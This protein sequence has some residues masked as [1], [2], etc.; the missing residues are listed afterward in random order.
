MIP[1]KIKNNSMKR[2]KIAFKGLTVPEKIEKA[3]SI[4]DKMNGNASFTTPDP[5]LAEVTKAINDLEA[6][7]NKAA[8]GGKTN[9]AIM[10]Q[11]DKDLLVLITSL[12]GYVQSVSR[13]DEL[14]I[15]SSG[16]E[17]AGRGSINNAPLPAPLGLHVVNGVLE[18]QLVL[19]WKKVKGA[20]NYVVQQANDPLTGSN[21]DFETLAPSSKTKYTVNDLQAGKKYWFRIAAIGISGVGAYSDPANKMSL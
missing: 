17:I 19:T 4:V 9:T 21:D 2:V 5:T 7:Q 18:G 1:N 13:G 3:R 11:R 10:H 15:L 14:V 20:L 16:F 6:A 12:A 8:D